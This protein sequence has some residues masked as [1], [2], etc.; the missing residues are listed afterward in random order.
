MY[1]KKYTKQSKAK[2]NLTP[3][4]TICTAKRLI[5]KKKLEMKEQKSFYENG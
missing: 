5:A 4:L 1:T 2:K 3:C